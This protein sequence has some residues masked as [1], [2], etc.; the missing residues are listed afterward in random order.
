M[1]IPKILTEAHLGYIFRATLGGYAPVEQAIVED[2][3]SQHS[4]DGVASDAAARYLRRF[5]EDMERVATVIDVIRGQHDGP[6]TT[7]EDSEDITVPN[8]G[9]HLD[10]DGT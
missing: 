1:P 7:D 4:F 8:I 10:G 3:L 5:A 9:I 2:M 6:G